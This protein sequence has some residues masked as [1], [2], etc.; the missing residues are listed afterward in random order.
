[1]NISYGALCKG[2]FA[3]ETIF[4]LNHHQVRVVRPCHY[5]SFKSSQPLN[6]LQNTR[7]LMKQLTFS[8]HTE[9]LVTVVVGYQKFSKTDYIHFFLNFQNATQYALDG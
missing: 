3:N 7:R 4:L 8:M 9:N 6:N 1:M 2:A 5:V